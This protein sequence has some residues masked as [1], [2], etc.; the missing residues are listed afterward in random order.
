MYFFYVFIGKNKLTYLLIQHKLVSNFL[1]FNEMS[2]DVEKVV[3]PH[4]HLVRNFIYSTV[5][6]YWLDWQDNFIM[7][8][9]VI[10]FQTI[11]YHHHHHYHQSDFFQIKH[12]FLIE[13]IHLVILKVLSFHF[14]TNFIINPTLT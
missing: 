11:H 7:L 6:H 14:E 2:P 12:K 9:H 13:L 8:N 10:L 5:C 3:H 1:Y 4:V